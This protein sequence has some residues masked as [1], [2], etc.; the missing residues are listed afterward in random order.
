MN[1]MIKDIKMLIAAIVFLMA[2][3]VVPASASSRGDGPTRVYVFG[4]AQSFTDSVCFM[5]SIQAMD[6][7]LLDNNGLLIDRGVYSAQFGEY[8]KETTGVPGLMLSLFFE[9]SRRKL[10]ILYLRVRSRYM[11]RGYRDINELPES[12]FRFKARTYDY[13]N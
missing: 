7:V 1:M 8:L 13:N 10:E 5:S 4:V 3:V 9:T 12:A 11:S 2:V 6:S